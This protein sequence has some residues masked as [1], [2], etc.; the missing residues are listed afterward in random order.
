MEN[1]SL[2]LDDAYVPCRKRPRPIPEP[3]PLTVDAS[4][5]LIDLVRE[6]VTQDEADV[7]DIARRAI[8]DF[9]EEAYLEA[10]DMS[11]RLQEALLTLR[12][13]EA[14][15]NLLKHKKSIM[16]RDRLHQRT[17]PPLPPP[18]CK[19]QR[20]PCMT[21]LGFVSGILIAAAFPIL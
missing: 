1:T 5:E 17:R 4:N 7:A 20:S 8:G 11:E 14:E 16:D 2:D 15:R 18:A 13:F 12:L 3:E 9:D 10:A 19:K 21:I 6:A